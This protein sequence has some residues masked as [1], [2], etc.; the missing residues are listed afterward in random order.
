MR[1]PKGRLR[2]V[3]VATTGYA[4]IAGITVALL[5]SIE[6]GARLY[7]YVLGNPAD[8]RYGFSTAREWRDPGISSPRFHALV[9]DRYADFGNYY[10]YAGFPDPERIP[11]TDEPVHINRFG[12]RG[13]DFEIAKKPGT[14]R[15]VTMGESSTFG[16]M[17][18]D[19]QTYPMRL[20][21]IFDRRLGDGQVEVINAGLP[22]YTTEDMS[23]L[24]QQ[25]VADMS[26]DLV[27][28]Y[29]GYNDSTW[30]TRFLLEQRMR[31]NA[32]GFRA[33]A[34]DARIF[35]VQHSLVASKAARWVDARLRPFVI[36]DQAFSPLAGQEAR[37]LLATVVDEF[38]RR[39]L[40]LHRQAC[41]LGIDHAFAT[42]LHAP[43]NMWDGTM[44]PGDDPFD[45][46]VPEAREGDYYNYAATLSA[47]LDGAGFDLPVEVFWFAQYRVN[48]WLLD[49]ETLHPLDFVRRADG[50][51]NLLSTLIHLNAQGNE[52]LAG[53]L[54]DSL[55]GAIAARDTTTIRAS[56]T[57]S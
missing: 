9:S 11:W 50:D 52:A 12:L 23:I 28:F 25:L 18:D 33:A 53:F 36:T 51:W 41:S 47:K 45:F 29:I 8:A 5:L 19:G 37:E 24:L 14:F 35:L 44:Q 39:V 20:Q 21:E 30:L 48:E 4:V 43:L 56:C 7:A 22:Y 15:L 42:E 40:A 54:A 1:A 31:Q 55:Q 38:S 16:F 32:G 17:V 34:I 6:A 49:Q 26:P 10:A 3:L 27:T 46:L 57:G 2:R 13:P